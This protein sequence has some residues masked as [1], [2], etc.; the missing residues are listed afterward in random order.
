MNASRKLSFLVLIPVGVVTVFV[1]L[2]LS[3][4]VTWFSEQPPL[5]FQP[6]MDHNRKAI[7]QS[8]NG[9]FADGAS[10]RPPVDGTVG[11][12]QVVYPLG[13]GDVEQAESF[14][15]DPMYE[16][17]EFLLAR[18]QNRFNVFCSPCHYYDA[19]SE[20]S[21]VSQKGWPGIPDLTRPETQALSNARIFHIISAGQNLMPKYAD[22]IAPID[23]WAII[24]Y[25][26]TLQAAASS[27]PAQEN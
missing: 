15:V 11:R 2:I 19:H 9:F 14:N 3:G 4:R 16:Q 23:R 1:I 21:A 7:T 18:G 22:K 20:K 25:L 8:A 10:Q 17:T 6:N 26:R 13:M 24:Y 12:T 5:E 27:A